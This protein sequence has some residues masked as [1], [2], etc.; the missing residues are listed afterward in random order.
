MIHSRLTTQS[1]LMT[2]VE[3][4]EYLR[5]SPKTLSRWRWRGGRG[6]DFLRLGSAVR[7]T[8]DALDAFVAQSAVAQ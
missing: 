5:L 6:P 4:A 1:R 2:E 3:A 7:Y 8:I